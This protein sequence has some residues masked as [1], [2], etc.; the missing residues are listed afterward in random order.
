[1]KVK[2]K[3]ILWLMLMAFLSS[4]SGQQTAA[5][6]VN[7]SVDLGTQGKYDEA[8]QACDKAIELDPK[9]TSAWDSKGI[10]LIGQSKYNESIVL[11]TRLLNL[12]HKMKWPGIT[13]DLLSMIKP[14][15]MSQF[16]PMIS[17]SRS[18]LNLHW[19]GTIKD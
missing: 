7:K 4:A 5:D 6:W 16:K 13:K 1:M 12:I 18:I 14:S 9:L 10:A 8:I 19:L 11:S 17:L 15:I 2:A 3:L